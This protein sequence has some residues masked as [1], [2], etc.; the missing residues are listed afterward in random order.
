MSALIL[1]GTPEG[2]NALPH[3]TAIGR[4]REAIAARGCFKATAFKLG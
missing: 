1:Y 3:H 2:Q 4:W